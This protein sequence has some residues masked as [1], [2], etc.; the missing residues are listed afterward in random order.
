ME[1]EEI[2]AAVREAFQD[3]LKDFYID[4]KTH[5]EQHEFIGGMMKYAETCKSVVLKAVL[6]I[7]I[8]GALGLMWLG[9]TIR[10]GAK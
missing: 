8:G 6:T 10:H 7:L 4:R 5:Y 2:K 1:K 3:E 9:F